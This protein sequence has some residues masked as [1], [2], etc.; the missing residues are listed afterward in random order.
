MEKYINSMSDL[1]EMMDCFVNKISWN[2]FYKERKKKA[3]FIEQ[4]ELADENLVAFLSQNP[5]LHTALEL[6]CGE[7]RNA[8]YLAQQNVKVTAI[9]LSEVSIGNAK[10]IAERKG[11]QVDFIC[12]NVF[13]MALEGNKYDLVYDS[14]MFHHLAPHRRLQYLKLLEEVVADKGYFGLT[15]FAWGEDCA[16]EV[17]DWAFYNEPRTGVAFKEERL[18]TFFGQV[19]DVIEIRRYKNGV[20]HTIQGLDFMW[21]CLF[22]KKSSK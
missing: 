11:V 12:Q 3:P 19:F 1:Y 22:K 21:T 15:C 2:E 6:G 16:D 13:N 14:G 17:D 18:R 5:K 4:N 9:D 7:G 8:I 10:V 20:P